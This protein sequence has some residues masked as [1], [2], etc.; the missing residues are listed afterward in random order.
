[1]TVSFDAPPSPQL[2][3]FARSIQEGGVKKKKCMRRDGDGRRRLLIT[4][5]AVVPPREA[6]GA[7]ARRADAGRQDIKGEKG[8]DRRQSVPSC[9]RA[10]KPRVKGFA[11]RLAPRGDPTWG[12]AICW[13]SA[14]R[15][16]NPCRLLSVSDGNSGYWEDPGS[17]R[18]AR[19]MSLRIST[20]NGDGRETARQTACQDLIPVQIR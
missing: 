20:G 18:A 5:Q 2:L 17:S 4:R 7:G 16:E 3:L 1:M 13:R 14:A 9:H 6:K 10:K 19:L 8:G 11:V 15:A 12:R